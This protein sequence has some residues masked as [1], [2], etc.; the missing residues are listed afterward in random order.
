MLTWIGA[1]GPRGKECKVTGRLVSTFS[2][3]KE[4]KKKKKKLRYP[5]TGSIVPIY[6]FSKSTRTRT[7]LEIRVPFELNTEPI[8]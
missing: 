7:V 4:L 3:D 5:P 2:F 6:Q 8:C 1:R